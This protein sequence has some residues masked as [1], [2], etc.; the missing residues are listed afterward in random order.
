MSS[1]NIH[2]VPNGK[3]WAVKEEGSSKPLSTHS[4]KELA[5]KRA[6]SEAKS[7]HSEH[8]IHGRN[9]QIQDKDS[10]GND[11]SRIIDKKH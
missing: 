8:V 1:K 11:P 9:G 4:T 6:I 10:Y 3:R 5:E 7:R 2:T